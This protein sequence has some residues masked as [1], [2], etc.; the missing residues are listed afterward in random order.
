MNLD[1]GLPV[2]RLRQ[3]IRQCLLGETRD[4]Q[5]EMD[6]VNGRG[7]PIQV[8]VTCSALTMGLEKRGVI[9]VIADGNAPA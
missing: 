8:S 6:A 7:K 5:L 4:Q 1:I 9:L 3:P 2:E